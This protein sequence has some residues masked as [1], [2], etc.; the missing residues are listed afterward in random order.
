[1]S[2][3]LSELTALCADMKRIALQAG[4]LIM[5]HYRMSNFDVRL[6]DDRSPVT[7]A[8]TASESYILRALGEAYPSI[9]IISEE[10][11]SR[12]ALPQVGRRCFLVDP[13]DGTKNYL[14]RDGEFTVN[15]AYAQKRRA[16]CGVL[17]APAKRRLFWGYRWGGAYETL[18]F[19]RLTRRLHVGARRDKP[20]LIVSSAHEKSHLETLRKHY[21]AERVLLLG[22]ALKFGLLACGE[23]D[24][25]PRSGSTMAWD[26]A[27]GQAILEAAGGHVE[28]EDGRP[29]TYQAQ[30][31]WK[32]TAF[33]A[34]A[35]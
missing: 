18:P 35:I 5:R 10:A 7:V 23:A 25:Y 9:P 24:I 34:R 3:S 4:H 31:G 8:D 14:K 16:L 6:K 11:A 12:N 22:S 26:T 2:I 1:M 15:I 20:R 28:T 17:Y 33:L 29:L 21:G 27:A 13:L 32:N 19:A 30:N